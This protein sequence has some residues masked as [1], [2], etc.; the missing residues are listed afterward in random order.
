MWVVCACNGFGPEGA[1]VA[2]VV[3][4]QLP[5]HNDGQGEQAPVQDRVAVQLPSAIQGNWG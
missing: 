3:E 4:L 2:V 5:A 1:V